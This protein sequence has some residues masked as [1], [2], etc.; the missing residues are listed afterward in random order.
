MLRLHEKVENSCLI[1]HPLEGV[2]GLGND[3]E[4]RQ[5]AGIGAVID[6]RVGAADAGRRAD[7]ADG[8]SECLPR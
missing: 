4:V 5:R 1:L 6:E 7:E 8:E 3:V 2:P